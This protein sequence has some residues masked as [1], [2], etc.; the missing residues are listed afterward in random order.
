MMAKKISDENDGS[1]STLFELSIYENSRIVD[2]SE[3]N[4]KHL[5]KRESFPLSKHSG[6]YILMERV[7]VDAMSVP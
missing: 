4:D 1:I 3:Y 7:D 5:V 6:M 2:L